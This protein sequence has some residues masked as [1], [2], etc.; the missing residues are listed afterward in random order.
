MKLEYSLN[1]YIKIKSI[2]DL[3]PQSK[4][5][6]YKTPRGK[7]RQNT[8]WHKLQQYLFWICLLNQR[9]KKPKV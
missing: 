3:R 6:Y 2:I 7:H 1:L 9:K 8:L 5:E 4:T